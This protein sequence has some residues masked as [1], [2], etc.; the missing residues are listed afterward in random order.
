M[1]CKFKFYCGLV[2]IFVLGGVIGSLV[3][4]I[5]I[6]DKVTPFYK[7]D[8]LKRRAMML[9]R[10]DNRLDLTP[11]Q[12]SEVETIIGQTQKEM[13]AFKQ[14]FRPERLKLMEKRFSLIRKKLDPD[15]QEKLDKIQ[16]RLIHRMRQR[17]KFPSS[18][19][20]PSKGTVTLSD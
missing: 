18:L 10:L 3:T 13:M 1:S 9:K 4:G 2:A 16:E 8:P 15:Q 19:S 17:M 7:A 20:N 5:Y 11:K 14:K 12:K 6:R